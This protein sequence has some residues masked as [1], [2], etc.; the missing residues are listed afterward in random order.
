MCHCQSQMHK[1][2]ECWMSL[3]FA[4]AIRRPDGYSIITVE[5]AS[6]ADVL[7]VFPQNSH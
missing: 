1:T 5:S 7:Y 4:H 2:S 6:V 3:N